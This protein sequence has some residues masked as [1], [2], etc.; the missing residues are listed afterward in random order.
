MKQRKG[1]VVKDA[2]GECGAFA[3]IIGL[4]FSNRHLNQYVTLT[5]ERLMRGHGHQIGASYR[6]L[7]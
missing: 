4:A 3:G 2:S 5:Y 6:G 7:P 1:E